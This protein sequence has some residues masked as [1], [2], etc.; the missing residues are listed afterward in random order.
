MTKATVSDSDELVRENLSIVHRVAAQ[1]AVRVPRFVSRDEL[2]SAGMLGLAQA[3]KSWDPARGVPFEGYARIRV[4]GAIVD[5]LR[6]RD[7]ATRSIRSGSRVLE[8]ATDELRNRLGRPATDDELATRLNVKSDDIGRMRHAADR[9]T[10]LRLDL[11]TEEVDITNSESTL[12]GP[13]AAVLDGELR[14]C[15]TAAIT[16]LPERLRY[17][18]TGYFFEGREMQELATGMGV[19]PSRVSQMCSEAIAL[20]RDGINSRLAPE[21]VPDLS[22][23][24]G[25]IG[26]RKA[27]Y[28]AAVAE[29]STRTDRRAGAFAGAAA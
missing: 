10:V 27:A 17:V 16:A 4:R 29:A 15:L 5:D 6:S 12:D 2:V 18:V 23:T 14:E 22:A 11:L 7:W 26:R 24:K 19:T 13:D 21:D 3:A 20:L 8:A 9:A 28:Y 1:I 25:R